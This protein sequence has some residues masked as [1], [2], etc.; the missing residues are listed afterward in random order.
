MAGESGGSSARAWTRW[1]DWVAVV[2]G[3]YLILATML[4]TATNASALL[5][6]L[7]LGG[8]LVIGGAWS[9][10]M[11]GSIT[12]EYAH[13]LLGVLLF[14]SPWV[15]G[16]TAFAGAA[17]T[18]WVVGALAVI[19]GAAALPEAGTAHRTGGMAAQH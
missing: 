3:A 15:L 8:L 2:L 17:W 12:S 13:M 10:A 4:W 16:Y 19:A 1:Q 7:V 6:M 9:L 5:T 14:I 11:P 18:S